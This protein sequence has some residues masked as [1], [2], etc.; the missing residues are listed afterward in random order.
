MNIPND[1]IPVNRDSPFSYEEKEKAALQEKDASRHRH[2]LKKT[3]AIPMPKSRKDK[4]QKPSESGKIPKLPGEK[5]KLKFDSAKPEVSTDSPS[6][7]GS[8]VE[9]KIFKSTKVNKVA[10]SSPQVTPK[11]EKSM[12]RTEEVIKDPSEAEERKRIL[13][14]D[15]REVYKKIHPRSQSR[16]QQ[17]GRKDPMK[18]TKLLS[19]KKRSS[20]VSGPSGKESQES[21]DDK[22]KIKISVMSRQREA[23]FRRQRK[24]EEQ[25]YKK[26]SRSL[27]CNWMR[28]RMQDD[29]GN[30]E[31]AIFNPLGISELHNNKGW[32]N[33]EGK[34]THACM[35]MLPIFRS[36]MSG[37]RRRERTPSPAREAVESP[38]TED[39][40][41]PGQETGRGRKARREDRRGGCSSGRG[42]YVAQ[43]SAALE[44]DE[45][46]AKECEERWMAAWSEVRAVEMD[47]A[48]L[49]GYVALLGCGWASKKWKFFQD[50]RQEHKEDERVC[51]PAT[52]AGW[53][54]LG[55]KFR[56]AL[57]SQTI[58][59]L[60]V[61]YYVDSEH[62]IKDELHRKML[63]NCYYVRILLYLWTL[64]RSLRFDYPLTETRLLWTEP[65]K[66]LRNWMLQH[67]K[68]RSACEQLMQR[69]ESY[70]DI[71]QYM[72]Q[73][74]TK[75]QLPTI[76]MP[77]ILSR[78]ELVDLK[79]LC[80]GYPHYYDRSGHSR[81][82]R[83]TNKMLKQDC[84]PPMVL[85][86]LF[87]APGA[88]K[89]MFQP[90]L[91]N[92]DLI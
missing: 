26:R 60:F 73:K 65:D 34:N 16:D 19:G 78:E 63:L 7:I 35:M 42:P 11:K 15:K 79:P 89:M 58:E 20:A 17:Q 41:T 85:E 82:D 59:D 8:S 81:R 23:E 72:P 71:H 70:V 69:E 5:G 25:D 51:G 4:Q 2:S 18:K 36:E 31:N 48:C 74:P 90:Y 27:P 22:P 3:E 57:E 49:A 32:D 6:P 1:P 50:Y 52:T 30:S 76:P 56:T 24:E 87:S 77:T 68:N 86:G 21:S 62:D 54:S 13:R 37:R 44:I 53:S 45:V 39:G 61:R 67:G 38:G 91:G 10:M 84:I 43:D 88:P 9:K 83:A 64:Y 14:T 46:R 66:N 29:G 33:S 28:V 92:A 12:Q 55:S 40:N 80:I 47:V 75:D